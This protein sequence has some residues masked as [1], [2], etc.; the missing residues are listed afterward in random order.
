MGGG[1]R[2]ALFGVAM[3]PKKRVRAAQGRAREAKTH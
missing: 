3:S 2:N 1:A